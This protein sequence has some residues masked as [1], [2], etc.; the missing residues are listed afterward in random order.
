MPTVGDRKPARP[1]LR[2]LR[3]GESLDFLKSLSWLA[4]RVGAMLMLYMLLDRILRSI[5]HLPESSY[6]LPVIVFELFE[7]LFDGSWLSDITTGFHQGRRLILFVMIALT[8]CAALVI[9]YPSCW[10]NYRRLGC[11]WSSL[12]DG[13]A[14]RWLI[15]VVVLLATWLGSTYDYN[16]FFNQA[17]Y[18]DRFSLILLGIL[19]AWRPVFVFS[20]LLLLLGIF[21][22]FSYPYLHLLVFGAFANGWLGFCE[23][24]TIVALSRV[25][26]YATI[27]L[28]VFTLLI[29]WGAIR[30][31]W[32]RFLTLFARR[33]RHPSV[34]WRLGALGVACSAAAGG[35]LGK[36][37]GKLL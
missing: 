27:P 22:Q 26:S 5:G 1:V 30:F 2:A 10:R 16:L 13:M 6:R 25:L 20:F 35:A 34:S 31:L 19:I 7:R 29:E 12:V 4:V 9:R 8:F 15:V 21:Y 23:S 11:P 3:S 36:A 14:L 28:M 17:H 32:R 24:F 18:G 37:W 33:L